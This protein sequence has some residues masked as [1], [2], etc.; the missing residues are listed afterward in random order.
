[1]NIE[2]RQEQFEKDM[3]AGG[4]RISPYRGRNFYRG[5]ATV[6]DREV[7]QQVLRATGLTLL[8]DEL[9]KENLVIYPK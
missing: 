2:E 7:L 3:K 9:G 8:W 1:M 6:I 4:W 5:P